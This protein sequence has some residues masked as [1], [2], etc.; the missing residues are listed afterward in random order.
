MGTKK[1]PSG[2][3]VCDLN[4][5]PPRLLW[6]NVASQIHFKKSQILT[7]AAGKDWLATSSHEGTLRIH[8]AADGSVVTSI[9]VAAQV[10][11]LCMVR[12]S[13]LLTGDDLGT[14]RLLKLP[15]GELVSE[16]SG[17]REEISGLVH[18][19]NA[20]LVVSACRRGEVRFWKLDDASSSLRLH[21]SIGPLSGPIK[22]LCI[23]DNRPGDFDDARMLLML[24]EGESAARILRFGPI[25][26]SLQSLGINW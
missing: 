17:H 25:E 9:R 5:G 18:S 12:D 1:P 26:E 6:S 21:A 2:L 4:E 24:V 7:I 11:S 22:R 23:S 10:T 19:E 15:E 14:I 13:L 3:F 20:R 8:H 16:H